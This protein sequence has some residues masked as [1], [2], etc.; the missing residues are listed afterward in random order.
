MFID[1]EFKIETLWYALSI[2]LLISL[3]SII[4]GIFYSLQFVN[5]EYSTH[6]FD[7]FALSP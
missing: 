5:S 4:I 7:S 3:A 6:P 2:D 1:M